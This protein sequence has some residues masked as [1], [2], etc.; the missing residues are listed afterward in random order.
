MK[1]STSI[2][3]V[4]QELKNLLSKEETVSLN[5]LALE[6]KHSREN[7]I[8]TLNFLINEELV[9]QEKINFYRLK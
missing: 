6:S 5:Q 4:V 8:E 7:V 2:G 1:N 9:V 3:E